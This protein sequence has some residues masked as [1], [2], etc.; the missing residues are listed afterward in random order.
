MLEAVQET[1]SDAENVNAAA[2]QLTSA[3]EE[4]AGHALRTARQ[5]DDLAKQ[6]AEGQQVIHESINGFLS[7]VDEITETKEQ[8]DRLFAAIG[9]VTDVVQ[10]IQDV[11]HQ[12]NL[13][14]LNAS[15]EAARAGEEGRGFA[16]V[17]DEI[18]RLA[19]Q[20]SNSVE[21]ITEMI[22]Q[23]RQSAHHVGHQSQ[24]MTDQ[25]QSRVEQAKKAIS[26][27]DFI[28]KQVNEIEQSAAQIA[29]IVQ[30]QTAA[31]QDISARVAV[32]IEQMDNVQQ[33]AVETGRNIYQ[34][35]VSLNEFRQQS[36]RTSNFDDVQMIRIVKTDHLLW[37]WWVYNS[38]LGYHTI[39]VEEVGD[40]HRCRLGQWYDRC[41]SDPRFASSTSFQQLDEPHQKI[42]RLAHEAAL[43][44]E[45]GKP[46]EAQQLLGPIEQVSHEVVQLLGQLSEELTT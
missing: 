11:A 30:E 36:I 10:F 38:L 19:E 44:L 14:A 26:S 31:T 21:Q 39:N 46:E 42:H 29:V 43:L 32:S 13:L 25:I 27:L 34:S 15:I 8:F 41:K 24:A 17:A 28:I 1:I 7:M 12:T 3:V 5:T 20:T 22:D 9:Q 18:R 4:V 37:R 6:A 35:S 16:V 2:E 45:A 23:V 40:H 33:H